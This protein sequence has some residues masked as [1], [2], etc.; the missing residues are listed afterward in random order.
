MSPFLFIGKEV[1]RAAQEGEDISAIES[2]GP[3]KYQA[4]QTAKT[5]AV[6][7]GLRMKL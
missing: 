6:D 1:E 3:I 7:A 2:G 5:R 4:G